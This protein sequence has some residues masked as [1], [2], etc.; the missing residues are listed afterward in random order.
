MNQPDAHTPG[1]VT[2]APAVIE[3]DS[4]PVSSGATSLFRP[5]KPLTQMAPLRIGFTGTIGALLA[6][7]L[8]LAVI[9]AR[10]TLILVVVA[11]F[12]ALGLNPA[13][14]LLERRGLRRGLA[15]PTVF[16]VVIAVAGLALFA[17][18]P[19]FSAQIS[20]LVT[21]APQL[22][23]DLLANPQVR[24]LNDRY[25]IV[26]KAQEY[27]RSGGLLQQ[28]FGGLLGAGRVVLGA[29]LS[30]LTVLILTLYF[31]ASLPS[32]K[33]AIGRLSPLSKRRRVRE[34]EDQIFRQV[35]AY[36]VGTFVVALIAAVTTFIFLMIIG[37]RE[38]ALALA[39][40]VGILDIIPLIGATIAAVLV[41][42]I[43]FV[44]SPVI[45]ITAVVYYLIYQQLENY[46]IQPRVFKRAV[47]IPGAV[48]VIGALLGGA[49][50]GVVGALLAGPVA[51]AVLLLL[52]EVI[53]PRL[54]SR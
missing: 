17:V 24:E 18:V 39:V 54:D 29:V 11:F 2:T 28:A 49:L 16:L 10:S 53:Q 38:Y 1:S 3:P 31:L 4:R 20:A 13:V 47:D 25:Q 42:I 6:Y 15:V 27:V 48:V 30:T 8:A 51:A 35:G 36:L 19:V 46:V 43:A 52:R 32:I 40:L 34:L 12:I 9:E 7:G 22:L 37:L 45:G 50:L 26:T 21:R 5:S 23:Q 14:E 41:C 33:N 44:E